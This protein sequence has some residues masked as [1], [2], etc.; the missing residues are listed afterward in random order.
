[1]LPFAL[2]FILYGL[3]PTYM[4]LLFT[5]PAGISMLQGCIAFMLLGMYVTRRMIQIKV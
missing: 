5:D 3:N 2:G 4:S 1:V